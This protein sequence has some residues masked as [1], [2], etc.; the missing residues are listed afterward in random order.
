[1]AVAPVLAQECR[2]EPPPHPPVVMTLL[3]G[4]G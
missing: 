1:M 2:F 4:T 3:I